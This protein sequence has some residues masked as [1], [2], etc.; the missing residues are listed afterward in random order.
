MNRIENLAKDTMKKAIDLHNIYNYTKV[1]DLLNLEN[2]PE[3][4]KSFLSLDYSTKISWFCIK[5]NAS[6]RYKYK[7]GN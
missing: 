4:E 2:S 6:F 1:F 5:G 7:R 3:L